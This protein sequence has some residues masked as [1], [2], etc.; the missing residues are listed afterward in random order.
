MCDE[1]LS[2]ELLSQSL[3]V[4]P[5]MSPKIGVHLPWLVDGMIVKV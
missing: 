5:V 3:S 4:D 2:D 1:K